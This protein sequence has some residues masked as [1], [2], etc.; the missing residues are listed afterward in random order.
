[1]ETLTSKEDISLLTRCSLDEE[2]R[3][4]GVAA[5]IDFSLFTAGA[6]F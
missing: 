1:M 2:A 3:L 5:V 6:V 4:V